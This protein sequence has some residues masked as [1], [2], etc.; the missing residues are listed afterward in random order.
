MRILIV[1]DNPTNQIVIEKVL[2]KAGYQQNTKLSSAFELIDYLH[3]NE[4]QPQESL[5]EHADADLILLDMM[6]PGMDGIEVCRLI[7]KYP[8]LK[9]IPIIMV[10]AVG[11]SSKLAEALD[12][13]AIDFVTKP[14]NK[15][16]LLARIRVALRL[17]YEKDWHKNQDKIIRQELDLARQVQRGVMSDTLHNEALHIDALYRP[18][19]QLAGDMYAWQQLDNGKYGVMIIDVMGHGISSALVCMFISSQIRELLQ[20]NV[21]PVEMMQ[22]LN[23]RMME[24]QTESIPISYYFTG[25]YC[26][27]DPVHQE[28]EYVNAGHPPGLLVEATGKVRRLET[29][30]CAIG[31]FEELEMRKERISFTADSKLYLYTDGLMEQHAMEED[32]DQQIKQLSQLFKRERKADME[33]LFHHFV[34]TQFG[35]EQHDDVCLVG[36]HIK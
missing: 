14:I 7:Q 6:M 34:S 26:V 22:Q 10:T 20:R 18:S 29:S 28:L 25:I 32:P 17:K 4:E 33:E 27:I 5:F 8:H 35:T 19:S 1:D 23:A 24:L 16:E 2:Q 21:D 13:G 36:V 31:M 12:A 30:S 9:D 11:D 15:I 3:M